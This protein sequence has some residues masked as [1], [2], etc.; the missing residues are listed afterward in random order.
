MKLTKTTSSRKSSPAKRFSMTA[1]LCAAMMSLFSIKSEAGAGGA[2]NFDGQNC[3]VDIGYVL[4]GGHSYTKEAWIRANQSSTHNIITGDDD[5]FWLSGDHLRAAHGWQSIPN[6][7]QDPETFP[8]GVWTH[9]AVTYD[10]ATTTMKLYKNGLLV[11]S[12][13]TMSTYGTTYLQV[14]A[15]NSSNLFDG[16]IDEVRVW[17]RALC[18]DEIQIHMN[19]ELAG[20]ESGLIVYY[21]F[22]DGI[23][24]ALNTLVGVATDAS[25]HNNNGTLHNFLLTGAVAN[26]V[27]G[28]VTGAAGVFT[29][30][31]ASSTAAGATI[32]TKGSSVTLTANASAGY[33][34]TKDAGDIAGATTQ[35]YAASETG[36]YAVRI[37]NDHGCSNTSAPVHV[38]VN[39]VANPPVGTITA[40]DNI[41]ACDNGAG[42]SKTLAITMSNITS[43]VTTYAITGATTGTGTTTSVT[44]NFNVGISTITWTV[45]DAANVTY[46]RAA[47]VTINELPTATIANS[48]A[49]AFCDELALMGKSSHAGT[50]SYAWTYS[51]NSYASTQII[52]LDNSSSDGNYTVKVTDQ[53]GCTNTAAY[54]YQKQNTAASYTLLAYKS[55]YLDDNN[56][57]LSGAIGVMNYGGIIDIDANGTV[58]SPGFL[59]ASTLDIGWTTT[60]PKRYYSQASVTLPAALPNTGNTT[61]LSST[62]KNYSGTVNGNYK[63]LTIGQYAYVTVNGNLFRNITIGQNAHVTFTAA[64]ISV[65]SISMD[66]NSELIFNQNTNF[67]VGNTITVNQGCNIN[68]GAKK[69]TFF[70]NEA[71][72]DIVK[73]TV[74]N[75]CNIT[76]NIF[77]PKG[78]LLVNDADNNDCWKTSH[79]CHGHN[80][81]NCNN[82]NTGTFMIGYFIAERIE[83]GDNVTWDNFTCTDV[84]V[85][86]PAKNEE[87]PIATIAQY[88][89]DAVKVFP[90][91]NSGIFTVA[92]PAMD[93]KAEVN[94]YDVTGKLVINKTV[95]QDEARTL[96][97]NMANVAHGMYLVHVTGND[98][99]YIAKMI[100]Q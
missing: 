6:D 73:F 19:G 36:D 77:M 93:S 43:P 99:D 82:G 44:K 26:F 22:N 52:Y 25:G 29:A 23:L 1:L 100:V 11:A 5:P 85:G 78:K 96:Q 89:V 18:I 15:Y 65:Q 50:N 67:R 57:I 46:T 98:V 33:Q 75:N 70:M 74:G 64:D 87:E 58:P 49:D 84:P 47:T 91:P 68:K 69:V 90:N 63:D 80:N 17:D 86:R 12:S 10:A 76:A 81:N 28:I 38:T 97:V 61:Y 24:G 2:L 95:A 59:K 53:N 45:K 8:L 37:T 31:A 35:T 79:N 20:S 56:D 7:I 48:K 92:L 4:Q 40:P 21:K 39:P 54:N 30:P 42:N 9:V 14:G 94:I 16:D 72:P 32:V 66:N 83:A 62:T 88:T 27:Q 60:A 34:W 71:T 13:S 55:I 3:Y 51:G 41:K